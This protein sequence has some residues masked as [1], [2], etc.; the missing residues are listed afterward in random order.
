[1]PEALLAAM[2]PISQASIEA[3]SGPILRRTARA[4]GWRL[5]ADDARLQTYRGGVRADLT[6]GQAIADQ[7]Q[8]PSVTAWPDRLVPAARKV[9]GTSRLPATASRLTT[10]SSLST[11]TTTP[12]D[13]PVEA[14]VGTVGQ[15]AQRIGDQPLG[16][17]DGGNGA[18]QFV[19]GRWQDCGS[20]VEG[21]VDHAVAVWRTIRYGNPAR[22]GRWRLDAR[23][24]CRSALAREAHWSDAPQHGA[25][26]GR[27][28]RPLR[29][30]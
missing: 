16:R 6:G 24:S 13:Q 4:S 22:F 11:T 21:R 17:D 14:G 2:P 3:G 7:H 18:P 9:T 5:A 29:S 28:C 19:V 1:M 30:L 23:Q 27:R 25:P 12:G 15:Q 8:A 10:S 26:E 20:L